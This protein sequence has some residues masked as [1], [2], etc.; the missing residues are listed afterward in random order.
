[1]QRLQRRSLLRLL[2]P[3]QR[4]G[5]AS[6]HL[7]PR[8]SGSTQTS[9]CHHCNQSS[10]HGHSSSSGGGSSWGVSC[11]PG[12]GQGPRQCAF[13]LQSWWREGF[14]RFS[15]FHPLHPR[16]GPRDQWTL[17]GEGHQWLTCQLSSPLTRKN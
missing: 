10:C 15:L 5:E 7:Q 16:L 14:G 13:S 8:A 12:W 9:F 4:L 2:L 1:M 17:G 3:A 11:R 6:P